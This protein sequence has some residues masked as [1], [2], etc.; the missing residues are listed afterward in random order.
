MCVGLTPMP[1][2][3]TP[4]VLAFFVHFPCVHPSVLERLL[5]EMEKRYFGK[6]SFRKAFKI[7]NAITNEELASVG[8]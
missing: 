1:A 6:L 7:F 3:R 4:E 8:G 5:L 2:A